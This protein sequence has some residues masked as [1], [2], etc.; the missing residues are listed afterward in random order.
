MIINLIII[1][2][3]HV[4]QNLKLHNLKLSIN[5]KTIDIYYDRSFIVFC[6]KKAYARMYILS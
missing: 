1:Y 5:S 2:I 6:L 4:S 3:V